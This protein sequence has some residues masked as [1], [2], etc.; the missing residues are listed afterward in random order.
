M[1]QAGAAA[2]PG[3]A[4]SQLLHCDLSPDLVPA[5]VVLPQGHPS[6]GHSQRGAGH[7]LLTWEYTGTGRL[8]IWCRSDPSGATTPQDGRGEG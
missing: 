4:T 5:S 3:E 1:G 8:N 6:E 2:A 7:A